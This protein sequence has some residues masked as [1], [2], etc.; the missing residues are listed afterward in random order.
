MGRHFMPASPD[1]GRE[2]E[3]AACFQKGVLTIPPFFTDQRSKRMRGGRFVSGM[4]TGMC[5]EMDHG[6]GFR[7]KRIVT[8]CMGV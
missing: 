3:V 2:T 8:A 1:F 5:H 6:P 7:Y 4:K